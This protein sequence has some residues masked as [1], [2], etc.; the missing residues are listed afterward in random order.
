MWLKN[1][2]LDYQYIFLK[3]FL[4]WVAVKLGKHDITK[5]LFGDR[6]SSAL[7]SSTCVNTQG[8]GFVPG[9]FYNNKI[10]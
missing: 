10:I 6:L 9:V 7:Q 5:H 3:I 2:R 1:L 8:Y 4:H